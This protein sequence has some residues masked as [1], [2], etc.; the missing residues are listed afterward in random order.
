MAVA[1][2]VYAEDILEWKPRAKR[3][4]PPLRWSSLYQPNNNPDV[5]D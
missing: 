5:L 4:A 2:M 1:V 3:V